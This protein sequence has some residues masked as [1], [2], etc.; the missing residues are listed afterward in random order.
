MDSCT[1]CGK[2]LDKS[3]LLF[4]A[5]GLVCE[6]CN[7]EQESVAPEKAL[8][9][10]GIGGLVVG[11]IPFVISFRQSSSTSVTV[12][13]EGVEQTVSESGS[14]FDYVALPAGALAIVLG[15]GA[16][17]LALRSSS[18]V[19]ATRLAIAA[20]VLAIGAFQVVRGLGLFG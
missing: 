10:I 6:P 5:S 15:V 17:I 3:Q 7:F 1:V 12:T 16:L 20:G 2:Q 9:P 8:T 4:T 13:T 19:K 18:K 11:L 14:S